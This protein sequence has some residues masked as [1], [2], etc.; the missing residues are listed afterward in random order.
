[1]ND[2]AH[3]SGPLTLAID[4]GG[5]RLKASVGTG[6]K[7][8]TLAD[9]FQ[10]F[11]SFGF[12]A[13]PN[14][15]PE[16]STGYDAGFEQALGGRIDAAI[17][18]IAPRLGPDRSV[19]RRF[20]DLGGENQRVAQDGAALVARLALAA[21][22]RHRQA[23]HRRHLLHRLGKT[24]PLD[25]HQEG[26][27]VAVLAGREVVVEALLV[28]DEKRRRLL[29]VERRQAGPFAPRLPQL[30]PR[31]DDLR[32]RHPGADF[33]EKIGRELHADPEIGAPKRIDKA[34]KRF[35]PVFTSRVPSPRP[36]G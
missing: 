3:P 35:S 24:E 21:L 23:R 17:G 6:F 5:T 29:G 31:A 12:F 14:L 25:L 1:M 11:P 33:V 9:L 19:E 26:E 28:V 32:H 10:N 20:E 16:T 27:D 18:K 4:I 15:K 2:A 13:N 8:P 34:G 30:H 22:G 7:A 36:L